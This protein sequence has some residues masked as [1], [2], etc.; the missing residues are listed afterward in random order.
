MYFL[1]FSYNSKIISSITTS[2]K[3]LLKYIIKSRGELYRTVNLVTYA[4]L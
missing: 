4:P 1:S 2:D 3:I